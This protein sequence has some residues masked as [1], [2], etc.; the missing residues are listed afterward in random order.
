GNVDL[1]QGK[2]R[3][4]SEEVQRHQKQAEGKPE[5]V[6]TVDALGHVH[7]DDNPVLLKGPKGWANLNTKDTTVWDGDYQMG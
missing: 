1:M 6:R 3:L 5:P 7:Y 2:S 4:H